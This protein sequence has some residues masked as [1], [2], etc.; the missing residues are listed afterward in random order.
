MVWTIKRTWRTLTMAIQIFKPQAPGVL[1]ID[2]CQWRKGTSYS[3]LHPV[4]LIGMKPPP[5]QA[6]RQLRGKWCDPHGRKPLA[7]PPN[8]IAG[9]DRQTSAR[10]L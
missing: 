5:S 7:N 8:G 3:V 4:T 10:Y 9:G 1:S 2:T 6:H